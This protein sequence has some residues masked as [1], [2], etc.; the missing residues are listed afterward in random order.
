MKVTI[1][2]DSVYANFI[3]DKCAATPRKA[4]DVVDYPD[5]YAQRLVETGKAT[6]LQAEAKP[7]PEPEP[8]PEPVPEPMPFDDA[9]EPE[10]EPVPAPTPK[11]RTRRTRRKTVSE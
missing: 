11:P 9:P 6:E 3:A 8:E 2:V 7:T 5:W 10:P 4:G 1:T